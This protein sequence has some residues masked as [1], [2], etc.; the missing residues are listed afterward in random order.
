MM[1]L[2]AKRSTSKMSS[3]DFKGRLLPF[4]A[5]AATFLLA[6]FILL[7][8]LFA[9]A[10]ATELTIERMYSDPR[11]TG[12]T[13]RSPSWSPDGRYLAFLWNDE[14][15][16]YY[17]LWIYDAAKGKLKRLTDAVTIGRDAS[18]VMTRAE[19]DRLA[20][21][22]RSG[23]GIFSFQWSPD[24]RRILFPY[25]GDLFLVD[26]PGGELKRLTHTATSET[27]ASFS[28]DGKRVAFVRENDIWMI[29]LE[30][31]ET[32]QLTD[33]GSET[34]YNGLGDYV[35]YEEVGRSRSF[36]WSPDGSK[37]A[38]IQTDVSP[39]REL[40]IPNY[41]GEFVGVREQLRPVAGGE[42]SLQRLGVLDLST[43]KTGWLKP[44]ERRD[45]YYVQVKWHPDSK[46]L[47]VLEEPRTMKC[48]RFLLY[49]VEE[50]TCDTLHT[51]KDDCWVN[52]NNIF[53]LWGDDGEVLYFTSEEKGWNHLYRLALDSG[54]LEQ[55][56]R[57]TWEIT[58]L[59]CIDGKGRVWFTST[60]VE[61]EQ[62]HLFYVDSS[63]K[64]F[65]VTE[66][67]GWY[68]SYVANGAKRVAVLYSNPS[69]PW[70]L[71]FLKSRKGKAFAGGGGELR[72]DRSG[73]SGAVPLYSYSESYPVPVGLKRITSS[74]PEDFEG[75][76][77]VTPYYFTLRSRL[78]GETI[79][80]LI[81]LPEELR[82][83]DFSKV[84]SGELEYS[85]KKYPVI[86]SVHGGGYAQ[87]VMKGWR[88]R[89]LFDSY[90]VQ[91]GYIVLD[92]DYRGSSGYGR[93]FRTDVYLRLMGPD[94]EDEM[95]GLEFLKAL[96]F[97]D[98]DR[99][100]I[101]GWSYGGFMTVAAMLKYPSAFYAGAAVAPVTDWHCYDTH[102]TEERLG[103]P[104]EN[105]EAYEKSSPISYAD[106]LRNHLLI[107][108]GMVDDNVHFQDTVRLVDK[109][110]GTGV[111]FEVMF[112]PEGKHG[113]R[114]DAARIHLFRKIVRHFDRYLKGIADAECR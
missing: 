5:L 16:R 87:S 67:S 29:D 51:I 42:N 74:Q 73:G 33:T 26:V 15:V 7:P 27:D 85:G 82:G 63:G 9:S 38:Y 47:L 52:I 101:W 28:P 43:L 98:G 113:I 55:M 14:G 12:V 45:I 84:L 37:I 80:A 95:T 1:A 94:L 71:Y 58:S 8:A 13:P 31:C 44:K 22:R 107:I 62:R 81:I 41:L 114:R 21:L 34:L 40:L 54:K 83:L 105:E 18:V 64:V 25:K 20:T 91:R 56:T 97:V 48:V 79:H 65:K 68:R 100:G 90:L 39:I 2:V 77:L 60:A 112:Y 32:V 106:S 11:L 111:D 104:Q 59:H 89:T 75:F 96:P 46:R 76:S 3:S 102:Y 66:G 30:R 103:L 17:D 69:R 93:K 36:W 99:I 110:I 78:D 53:T 23:G 19:I 72:K 57:G 10:R 92:L 109:L 61:P 49:G 50:G 35:D 108:H 70:D 86:V 6:L 4:V 88:W 24:G